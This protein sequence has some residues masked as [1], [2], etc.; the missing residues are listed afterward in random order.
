MSFEA[1]IDARLG[2][3]K[4]AAIDAYMRTDMGMFG[5]VLDESY[6]W[7]YPDG[8][9]LTVDRPG[10]DG[11]GGGKFTYFLPT[12]IQ[13]GGDQYITKFDE[14]RSHIDSLV[15]PWRSLKEPTGIDALKES[16]EDV[17]IHIAPNGAQSGGGTGVQAEITEIQRHLSGMT[18]A[19]IATYRANFLG[20]LDD[21]VNNLYL[22]A[23]NSAAALGAAKGAIEG[24]QQSFIE[25]LE[26]GTDA[27]NSVSGG[28]AAEFKLAIQI[29]STAN[30][31]IGAFLPPQA[32]AVSSAAGAVLGLIDKLAPSDPPEK[33]GA[34][35]DYPAAMADFEAMVE[36]VNTTLRD[37]E[38][39]IAKQA[40]DCYTTTCSQHQHFDLSIPKLS[41]D[42]GSVNV[43]FIDEAA[44]TD[45]V[46]TYMPAITTDL[47]SAGNAAEASNIDDEIDRNGSIGS[48]A[49][50][51][52]GPMRGLTSRLAD[53]LR[54][55]SW[56]TEFA[57]EQLRL[58]LADFQQ[59]DQ[60][61]ADALRK[62][63]EAINSN[64]YDPGDEYV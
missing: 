36:L 22:L 13:D 55:L 32:K 34:P 48:G 41:V 56:E 19:T 26:A 12:M 7:A 49:Q 42:E 30:S 38:D 51:P 27:F 4:R 21:V 28:G 63:E 50:G 46:S 44:I 11:N 62:H 20:V 45:I 18:G 40:R 6:M 14:I 31:V 47:Q 57:E 37:A 25:A 43:T 15:N 1:E 3:L 16:L 9:S 5:A 35:G 39:D 33:S 10:E 64:P 59:Q 23:A 52:S 17:Y 54:D 8:T 60:A 61:S 29:I 58:T 2:R 24:A 53:L